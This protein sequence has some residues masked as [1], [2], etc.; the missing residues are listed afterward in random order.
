MNDPRQDAVRRLTEAGAGNPRLDVRLLWD[1]A[2]HNPGIFESYVMRRIAH[3]PV[4]YITGRKEFWSLDLEVGPGVLIP[5]PDTETIIEQ[6]LDRFPN[7]GTPL[8]LLD[9]GTGSGCLLIALLKEFPKATGLGID[10][11]DKALAIASRNVTRHGLDGRATLQAGNWLEAL[12]GGWDVI[13]SNPPYIPSGDIAGLDPDVRGYEPL[14]ALDGGPDGLDAI[15][16]L[17]AGLGRVLKGY[18]FIEFGIG[19][20]AAVVAV[21]AGAGLE[22]IHIAADLGGIPRVLVTKSQDR[23]EKSVGIGSVTG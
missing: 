5:R 6:V 2:Q 10:S 16:V 15:R 12:D 20:S 19:Q 3:E 1:H 4:A 22:V 17:A 14:S 11:S 7:P 21:A 18:A 8:K 23:D 13:V 9:L